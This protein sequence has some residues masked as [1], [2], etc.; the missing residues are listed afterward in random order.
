MSLQG[1]PRL[2]GK[3]AIVTGGSRGIGERIALELAQNG[4]KVSITYTSAGS[5]AR[6]NDLIERINA[7]DNGSSAI[8]VKA[9]LRDPSSPAKIVAETIQNFGEHIDILVNNA[10]VELVKPLQ[11]ITVADFGFV[12][13]LNVRAPIL[14]LQSV[15]PYL[16]APGRIINIGSV[17]GRYGFKQLS[18]YCSSKSAL[19]GLTRCWAAELGSSGHTVNCVNPGPVQTDLMDNI[20]KETIAMQKSQTPIQNRIGTVEDIAPVVAWLAS[21]ESRWITGQV[22]SASGGWAMY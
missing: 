6:L 7:L 20:P 12:Y 2:S 19:E 8:A 3:V 17:G 9:D 13:D 14:M 5:E 11:E 22:V 1:A 16:R 21:E 18:V 15:L 10:G 4:A